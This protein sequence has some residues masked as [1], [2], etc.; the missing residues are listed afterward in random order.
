MVIKLLRSLRDEHPLLHP[1][2]ADRIV[3]C[4]GAGRQPEQGI[5][6]GS[7]RDPGLLLI[8]MG[9]L[10]MLV[11]VGALGYPRLRRIQEEL[12]YVV[13]DEEEKEPAAEGIRS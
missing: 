12:P 10:I 9:F 2:C 8:I 13:A 7:S 11:S 3:I 5:G 1:A 6:I 4:K